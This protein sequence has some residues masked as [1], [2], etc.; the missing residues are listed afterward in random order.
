MEVKEGV[1][2]TLYVYAE[3]II[4]VRKSI[5]DSGRQASHSQKGCTDKERKRTNCMLPEALDGV[6]VPL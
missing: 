2:E 3:K 6:V 5:K 4:H 1:S